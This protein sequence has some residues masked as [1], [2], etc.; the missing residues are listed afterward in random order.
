MRTVALRAKVKGLVFHWILSEIRGN[1]GLAVSG[2]MLASLRRS[3][4]TNVAYGA[5][6]TQIY[7]GLLW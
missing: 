1:P 4:V 5:P 2:D 7:N 3:C 6:V